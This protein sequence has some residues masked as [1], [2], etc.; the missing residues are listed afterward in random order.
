[1][2]H[3]DRYSMLFHDPGVSMTMDFWF[4]GLPLGFFILGSPSV[5]TVD[6]CEIGL[7]IYPSLTIGTESND[8]S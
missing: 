1:M 8:Q 3:D 5:P 4:E 2:V 7:S 6:H